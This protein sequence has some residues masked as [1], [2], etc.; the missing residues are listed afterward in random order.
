M[1]SP[2]AAEAGF[3]PAYVLFR[4]SQKSGGQAE[5]TQLLTSYLGIAAR[6]VAGQPS[7]D[8]ATALQEA[9]GELPGLTTANV[10]SNATSNVFEDEDGASVDLVSMAAKEIA[11]TLRL[12]SAFLPALEDLLNQP[13]TAAFDEVA[14]TQA[15][16]RSVEATVVFGLINAATDSGP[17]LNFVQTSFSLD[18]EKTSG[19]FGSSYQVAAAVKVTWEGYGIGSLETVRGFVAEEEKAGLITDLTKAGRLKIYTIED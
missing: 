13:V 5:Q 12:G 4:P 7:G 11:D 16:T 18:R 9:L 19:V 14:D 6:Y 2:V 10:S 8:G 17:S 15:K 1:S 3:Q